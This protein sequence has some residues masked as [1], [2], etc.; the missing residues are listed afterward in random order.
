VLRRGKDA[1]EPSE[2]PGKPGDPLTALEVID[3]LD[4]NPAAEG[5]QI[6]KAINISRS[7]AFDYLTSWG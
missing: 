3:F 5:R 6:A 1:L 7:N 4:L 2:R